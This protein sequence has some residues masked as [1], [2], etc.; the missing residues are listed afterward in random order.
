M[1]DW[2]VL[3]LQT[4]SMA[5]FLTAWPSEALYTISSNAGKH[6]DAEVSTS[7]ADVLHEG[8]PPMVWVNKIKWRITNIF[9]STKSHAGKILF[10]FY[11]QYARS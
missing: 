3:L 11:R 9:I 10:N 1:A 4:K 2:Q 7:A 8:C 6:S 5:P